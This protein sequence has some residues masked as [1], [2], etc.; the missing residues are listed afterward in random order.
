MHFSDFPSKNANFQVVFN[1]CYLSFTCQGGEDLFM[2]ARRC[3]INFATL[4]RLQGY[5]TH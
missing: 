3:E 4:R 1:F 2:T 5:I